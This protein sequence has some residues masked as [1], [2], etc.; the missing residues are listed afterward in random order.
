MEN[1]V[2]VGYELDEDRVGKMKYSLLGPN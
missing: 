2:V 1:L